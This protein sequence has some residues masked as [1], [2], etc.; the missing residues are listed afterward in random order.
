MSVEITQIGVPPVPSARTLGVASGLAVTTAAVI[1]VTAVGGDI[2]HRSF[3]VE[4]T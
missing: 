2:N 3:L 1:L 4:R